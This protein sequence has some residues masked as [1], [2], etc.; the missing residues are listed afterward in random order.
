M[1]KTKVPFPRPWQSARILRNHYV[2][3]SVRSASKNGCYSRSDVAWRATI[4]LRS[5]AGNPAMYGLGGAREEGNGFPAIFNI[6]VDSREEN[7]VVG[8]NAWVIGPYLKVIA[9]YYKMLEK[10]PNPKPV[11]LTE[12]G[13]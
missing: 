3:L 13:K 12:S 4:S 6:E 8:T 9:E 2:D 11:K 10:Y 5:S 7:N 1:G